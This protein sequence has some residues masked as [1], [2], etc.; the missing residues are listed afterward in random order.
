MTIRPAALGFLALMPALAYA[1]GT[2]A[3]TGYGPPFAIAY[4]YGPTSSHTTIGLALL[5]FGKILCP[6]AAAAIGVAGLR[7]GRSRAV[8]WTLIVAGVAL[9]VL[10]L[11]TRMP[12]AG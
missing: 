8:A 2:A 1:V 3:S 5:F 11:A 6:L 7:R 4:L 10:G 12:Y 9:L